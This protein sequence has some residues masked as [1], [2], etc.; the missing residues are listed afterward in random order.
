M[1]H[2]SLKR[3]L[4]GWLLLG[5]GFLWFLLVNPATHG[6]GI[7]TTV[8]YA[9]PFA[10]LA[11]GATITWPV[12]NYVASAQVTLG[13][14]RTLNVTGLLNGGIYQ[15]KI[16]QDGTGSRGLVLGTGCTWKVAGGGAGAITPSTAAN[17]VDLLEWT[18]DGTNCLASLTKNYT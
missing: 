18:Y 5:V 3:S 17:A 4:S 14:N 6:A 11:D 2:F 16:I 13:G 10:T 15:L 8:L 7:N 12:A 1:R 9:V